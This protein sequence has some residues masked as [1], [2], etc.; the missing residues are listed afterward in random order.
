MILNLSQSWALLKSITNDLGVP[1]P[2]FDFGCKGWKLCSPRGIQT[3][4]TE[5]IPSSSPC[6]QQKYIYQQGKGNTVWSPGFA[7]ARS[8][9]L[10]P[11]LSYLLFSVLKHEM[12]CILSN[13]RHF[14]Y[15]GFFQDGCLGQ[16]VQVILWRCLPLCAET[17][18]S[19]NC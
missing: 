1:D 3:V 4:S 13:T 15:A 17:R 16:M 14:I 2:D 8:E 19:W 10:L 5:R 11:R 6:L 9:L 7:E 12:G 18:K